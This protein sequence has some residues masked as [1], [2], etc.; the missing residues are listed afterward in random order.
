MGAF[1]HSGTMKKSTEPKQRNDMR[2]VPPTSPSP[3]RYSLL[4]LLGVHSLLFGFSTFTFAQQ[5]PL[6]L[7][8]PS[9]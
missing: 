6:S 9:R 1:G 8:P 5:R 2:R 3:I 7:K 4:T